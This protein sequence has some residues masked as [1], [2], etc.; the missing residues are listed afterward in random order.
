M[1]RRR[2]SAITRAGH[3]A[4]SGQGRMIAPVAVGRSGLTMKQIR[5]RFVVMVAEGSRENVLNF[6]CLFSIF[7]RP[8]VMLCLVTARVSIT[9]VAP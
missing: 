3:A 2:Q 8:I 1:A 7:T 5:R 4:R 6:P 9:A